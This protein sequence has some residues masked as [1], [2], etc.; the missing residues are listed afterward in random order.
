MY[1]LLGEIRKEL[2]FFSKFYLSANAQQKKNLKVISQI[3]D[4]WKK[5]FLLDMPI[6]TSW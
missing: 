2:Y 4:D 3:I 1:F 6:I 5:L